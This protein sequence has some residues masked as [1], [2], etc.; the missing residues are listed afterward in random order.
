M[1]VGEE[2]DRLR[3]LVA[4]VLLRVIETEDLPRAA[5]GEDEQER[6]EQAAE[7]EVEKPQLSYAEDPGRVA[8]ASYFPAALP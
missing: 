8:A 6:T 7:V 5:D 4:A 3:R 1:D 2:R